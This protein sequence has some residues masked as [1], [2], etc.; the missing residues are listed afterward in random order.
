M[1]KTF[2]L[3]TFNFQLSTFNFQLNFVIFA[4]SNLEYMGGFFGTISKSNCVAD[5][6]YGTDYNSHLGTKR[7]GMATYSPVKGMTRS[8]H[9]IEGAYFRSKFEAGLGKFDGSTS[10]IGV[11]SDTDAQP[12]IIHSHL[13]HFALVTVARVDNMDEV[14]AKLLEKGYH[15]TEL[16]SGKTNQTELIATLICEGKTIED[17]L[18]NVFD[19]ISDFYRGMS[20]I[21]FLYKII[22]LKLL[23]LGFLVISKDFIAISSALSGPSV[24]KNSSAI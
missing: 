12:I 7:A 8:I 23:I 21:N 3:S 18:Q 14:E 15:F 19:N 10:G 16:S 1:L 6:F 4:N 20:A 5:L 13:G 17:G 24:S 2:Q 11:I 9:N 22:K